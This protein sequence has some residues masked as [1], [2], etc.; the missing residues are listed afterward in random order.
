MQY[1]E[2]KLLSSAADESGWPDSDLP[3]IMFAGRSNAGKSSLIN[4]LTNRKKLA[5]TGKTPGKTR[6]LN[7]FEVDDRVVYC[8]SPGY[9]YAKGGEMS[10]LQFSDLIDPYIR[11]RKQLKALVLVL[12]IR[13]VPNDD[14]Q[15]M[16]QY[17]ESAG[18]ALIPACMK[19]DKLSRNQQIRSLSIIAKT[20]GIPRESCIPVSAVT[21]D[22]SELIEEKLNQII[23]EDR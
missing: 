12:D 15:L 9:G 14:D 4:L 8:D 21:R 10:V 16:K 6:L 1:H 20:L 3:E 17:A 23:Q 19:A 22:G 5:Y 13:R 18:L 7:F 11:K 2:A